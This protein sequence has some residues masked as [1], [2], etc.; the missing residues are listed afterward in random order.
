[1]MSSTILRLPQLR[2]KVGLSRSSIYLAMSQGM[3][4]RPIRIGVRSVG[5]LEAEVEAW[6]QLKRAKDA[7]PAEAPRVRDP[8]QINR[9]LPAMTYGR[10]G[11]LLR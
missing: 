9:S 6:I 2:L 4:P 7:E 8:A 11:R 5:W 10:F 1:M 3:F